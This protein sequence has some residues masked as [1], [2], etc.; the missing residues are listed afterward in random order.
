MIVSDA[1][2]V[3]GVTSIV[4]GGALSGVTT[5]TASGVGLF[6][7]GAVGAPGIAFNSDSDTGFYRAAGPPV[8][9]RV[10]VDGSY[11][12]QIRSTAGSGPKHNLEIAECADASNSGPYIAIGRNTGGSGAA[13]CLALA[14]NTGTLH[15]LW[16][17]A[18]GDL[19]ISSDP[20]QADGT[21]SDTSGTIVGTQS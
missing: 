9:L 13:A 15:W 18:T 10:A 3:T 14:D 17:D 8:S 2:A 12:A 19:R 7:D 6:G 21:P 1:G 20:P 5:L 16:V 11:I 4:M